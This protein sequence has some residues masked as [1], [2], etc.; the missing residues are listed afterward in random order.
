MGSTERVT[1][2]V[3]AGGTSRRMGTDKRSVVVDG[4]PMLVR[5][6]RAVGTVADTVLVACRR[7]DPPAPGLMAGLDAHI[8]H[9]RF[10]N[11]GPLAGIEAG[12]SAS[13]GDVAI[14]VAADM[15]CLSAAVLRHL[16]ISLRASPRVG[17]TVVRTSTG[18][19]PLL[20]AY[21][22]EVVGEIR[23]L[24][25]SGERRVMALLGAIQVRYVGPGAW[26]PLDPARRT[27]TSVNRPDDLCQGPGL[28][29]LAHARLRG[30]ARHADGGPWPP[31]DRFGGSPGL[32]LRNP[33]QADRLVRR[34]AG[35]P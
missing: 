6:V 31:G 30:N 28:V 23:R 21:R 25:D 5:A 18:P 10:E 1:G 34:V 11:A 17:A 35:V 12:L 24:L 4:V 9:D 14:V 3:L 16:A 29:P 15:P 32:R 33:G 13:V 8:V 19:E 22:P 20:A 26:M 2:I 7:E 27:A